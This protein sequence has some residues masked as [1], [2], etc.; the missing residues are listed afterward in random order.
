MRKIAETDVN[1]SEEEFGRLI[2]TIRRDPSKPKIKDANY[3]ELSAGNTSSPVD[4]E[5]VPDEYKE[6]I[7]KLKDDLRI[8]K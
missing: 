7:G 5:N 4:L 6:L 1:F 3:Y 2:Q 8:V